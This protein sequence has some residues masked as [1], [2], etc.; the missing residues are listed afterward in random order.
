[1]GDDLPV[2]AVLPATI[3]G[4]SVDDRLSFRKQQPTLERQ[5]LIEQSP[6]FL[7]AAT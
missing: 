2:H 7:P 4:R 1:M 3:F 5:A 6:A